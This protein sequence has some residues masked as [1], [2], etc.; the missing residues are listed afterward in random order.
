MSVI[1]CGTRQE[2]ATSVGSCRLAARPSSF[3]LQVQTSPRAIARSTLPL[4]RTLWAAGGAAE[5]AR[6][7]RQRMRA[8]RHTGH[9]AAQRPPQ[10][11]SRRTC[12]LW[13]SAC[14]LQDLHSSPLNSRSKLQS[15]AQLLARGAGRQTGGSTCRGAGR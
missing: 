1:Y 2:R 11:F 8:S 3:P 15:A 7:A 4:F 13:R 12:A 6:A 9:G 14:R 5:R 10:I